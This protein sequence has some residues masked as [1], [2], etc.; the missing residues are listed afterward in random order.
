MNCLIALDE[1]HFDGAVAPFAQVLGSG[2]ATEAGA[3]DDDAP[4]LL[5]WL[6]GNG[7][8]AAAGNAGS[9]GSQRSRGSAQGVQQAAAIRVEAGHVRAPY[10]CLAKYSA[11]TVIS[12]S[13]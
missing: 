4:E 9:S 2:G 11:S 6:G 8:E 12:S 1:R 10:F 5:A 3:D 7:S 13:V